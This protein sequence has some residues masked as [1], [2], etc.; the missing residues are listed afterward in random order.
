MLW[1][2]LFLRNS[3]HIPCQPS[4]NGICRVGLR[5]TFADLDLFAKLERGPLAE[6][7]AKMQINLDAASRWRL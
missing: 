5:P 7:E 4:F 1:Y 2:L 6:N 3:L